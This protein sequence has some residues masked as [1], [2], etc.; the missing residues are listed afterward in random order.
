MWLHRK[1][2]MIK[3]YVQ[4]IMSISLI[5]GVGSAFM[6]KHRGML[7]NYKD[8]PDLL[9][10]IG[11]KVTLQ[12]FEKNLSKANEIIDNCLQQNIRIITIAD[13]WYPK[14]LLEIKNPPPIIFYKGNLNNIKMPI[15]LIG[16]RKSTDLGNRIGERVTKYFHQDYSICNG[17]AE[18][19]DKSTIEPGG[20]TIE[21]AI[22]ILGGGL[23][24]ATS[25]TKKNARLAESVLDNDGLLIS[26]F[27]PNKKEDSFSSIKACRI[28]A[29][30]SKALILIQSPKDGG[31]KYTIKSFSEVDRPLGVIK[32]EGN[33]EYEENEIFSANRMIV[34]NGIEGIAKISEIKKISN[35]RTKSIIPISSSKNYE[36][37]KEKI[38]TVAN[39]A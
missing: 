7:L 10:N 11:G 37:I 38:K 32:Y 2:T 28:Q 24:L 17:L 1:Y 31:S 16:T 13:D 26:E 20:K 33:K 18:G 30:L 4:N 5:K 15:A 6:K 34:N 21:R 36:E 19:I 14:L 39:N 27:I 22:G 25:L 8:N 29:G 9:A 35:I 23:N 3:N 12:E